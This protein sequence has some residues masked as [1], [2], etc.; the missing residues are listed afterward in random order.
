M[1]QE[2]QVWALHCLGLAPSQIAQLLNLSTHDVRDAVLRC[3]ARDQRL[4][5]L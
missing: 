1:T 4:F 5:K 2:E 3:W